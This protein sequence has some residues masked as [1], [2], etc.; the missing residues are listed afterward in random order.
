VAEPRAYRPV[1]SAEAAEVLIGL[2]QRRQPKLL[3]LVQRL[4]EHPHVRPDYSIPDESGRSIDHLLV[5][6]FVLSY[7]LDHAVKELRI[8]EIDDAS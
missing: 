6:D 4:A 7:W 2:S 8:V 1:F 5:E 3:G